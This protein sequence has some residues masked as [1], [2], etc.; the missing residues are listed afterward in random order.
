V[1]LTSALNTGGLYRISVFNFGNQA[2]TS[3]N[4]SVS[5]NAQVQIVRGGTTQSVGN[6]TTIIGGRVI[7]SATVPTSGAG[8]TWVAAELDPRNGRI[9]IPRIINQSI[10]SGG[11]E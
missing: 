3:S 9:T 11:V 5:S 4:L 2:A 7:V 1:I 10:G 6:G 8:N